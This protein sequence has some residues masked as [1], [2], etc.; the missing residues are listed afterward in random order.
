MKELKGFS[1][2]DLEPGQSRVVEIAMERMYAPVSGMTRG[3][4]GLWSGTV[5]G[6]VV[7]VYE[8]HVDEGQRK[9]IKTRRAPFKGARH[10]QREEPC[11]FGLPC[12]MYACTV[13]TII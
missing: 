3:T 6:R 9:L 10:G 7:L 4:G 12:E 13:S 5:T 8:C 11:A 1:I 2:V